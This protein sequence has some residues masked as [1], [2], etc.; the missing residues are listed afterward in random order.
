MASSRARDE[1]SYSVYHVNS[2]G[3]VH[4]AL[5]ARNWSHISTNL[6]TEK[7]L[8]DVT[9]LS[10]EKWDDFDPFMR[11]KSSSTYSAK[12]KPGDVGNMRTGTQ[13]CARKVSLVPSIW[14]LAHARPD[15]STKAFN[16]AADTVGVALCCPWCCWQCRSRS[17]AADTVGVALCPRAVNYATFTLCNNTCNNFN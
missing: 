2:G 5:Q 10:T 12:K 17:C 4:W 3:L 1:N 9:K 7:T 6:S 11:K 13:N 14:R 8:P 16:C 15:L